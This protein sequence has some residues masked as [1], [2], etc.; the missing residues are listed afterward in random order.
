MKQNRIEHS[1]YQKYLFQIEEEQHKISRI[2]SKTIASKTIASMTN[3]G[4]T[5]SN[6]GASSSL[7]PPIPTFPVPPLL[8]PL[9]SPLSPPLSPPLSTLLL[10]CCDSSCR[11]SKCT[12]EIYDY[13]D[14]R[15][16]DNEKL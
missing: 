4:L 10:H 9:L 8:P 7:S 2:A 11:K 14:R 13:K 16:E 12:L 3:R 15:H 5:D 1:W 6:S